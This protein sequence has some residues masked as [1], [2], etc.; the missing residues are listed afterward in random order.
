MRAEKMLLSKTVNVLFLSQK[1]E[2]LC[3]TGRYQFLT[4][5]NKKCRNVK[6]FMAELHLKLE[7]NKHYTRKKLNKCIGGITFPIYNFIC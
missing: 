1:G 7:C 6:H 5:I 4:D 2:L 3:K